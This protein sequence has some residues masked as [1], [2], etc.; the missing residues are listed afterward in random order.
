MKRIVIALLGLA[1]VL[2]VAGVASAVPISF[3]DVTA[4][5]GTGTIS[6]G[7]YTDHGWG[8]VR[9]VN[10]ANDFIDWTHHLALAPNAGEILSATLILK[11]RDD[12]NDRKRRNKEYARLYVE[13]QD[14]YRFGEI[15]TGRYR[16]KIDPAL[17]M[18]NSLDLSILGTWG[19]FILK[20]SI[21]KITYEPFSEN[22]VAPVPEPATLL[23]LGTGL[24]GTVAVSRR[25][26]KKNQ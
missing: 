22:P 24:I 2:S 15:D 6:P 25:K 8:T 19:D 13:N 21:L 26:L 18:D 16:F 10:G 1:I 17:L 7:D 12:D 9:K 4:M 14:V 20:R 3:R 5:R 11:L 23:L